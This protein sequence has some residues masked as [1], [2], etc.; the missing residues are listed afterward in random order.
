MIGL[1]ESRTVSYNN[2]A[3][4]AY[5]GLLTNVKVLYYRMFALLYRLCGMCSNVVMVNGRYWIFKILTLIQNY[6]LPHTVTYPEKN[7]REPKNI[8]IPPYDFSYRFSP[9]IEKIA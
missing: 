3:R 7:S 5:N 9:K 6:A 8:R 4:I 2:D 1:V